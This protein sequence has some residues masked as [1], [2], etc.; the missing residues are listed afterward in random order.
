[1]DIAFIKTGS[2]G[3][4]SR[5]F[6]DDGVVLQLRGPDVKFNPPHDLGHYLVERV[7][8]PV[9]G[10]WGMIAAAAMIGGA[11]VVAGRLPP[12]PAERTKRLLREAQEAHASAEGLVVAFQR[13]TDHRLDRDWAATCAVLAECLDY[14]TTPRPASI[15]E[16]RTV[17]ASF[18]EAAGRWAALPRGEAFT[19]HWPT[20]W[21]GPS[22]RKHKAHTRRA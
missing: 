7:Y 16:V 5:V 19:V 15:E 20:P 18:R 3:Y 1:M 4:M 22:S 14:R 10:F 21:G 6:R 17:C 9:H 13:I 12:H 11:E 2:R 8:A